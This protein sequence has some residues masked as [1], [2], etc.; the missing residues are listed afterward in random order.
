MLVMCRDEDKEWDTRGNERQVGSRRPLLTT[1]LG[2]GIGM[3]ATGASRLFLTGKESGRLLGCP[4]ASSFRVVEE[5][6]KLSTSVDLCALVAAGTRKVLYWAPV[7][8]QRIKCA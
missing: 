6:V 8:R 4:G 1:D 3:I 5:V 2:V 7:K